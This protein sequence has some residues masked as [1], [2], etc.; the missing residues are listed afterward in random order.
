MDALEKKW[1]V[2]VVVVVVLFMVKSSLGSAAYFVFPL[3]NL[4][5]L[6]YMLK[7]PRS[8]KIKNLVLISA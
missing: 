1:W 8:S 5:L 4:Y 3:A 6:L 7:A 2:I